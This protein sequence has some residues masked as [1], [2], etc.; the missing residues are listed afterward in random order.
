VK[1][2]PHR[3]FYLYVGFTLLITMA[4]A[5]APSQYTPR[6]WIDFPKDGSQFDQAQAISVVAHAALTDGIGYVTL[7]VDSLPLDQKSPKEAGTIFSDFTFTW[8]PPGDGDYTLVLALYDAKGTLRASATSRVK[9]GKSL[10]F[11]P[12][13]SSTPTTTPTF[14][15]VTPTLTQTLTPI[16]TPTITPTSPLPITLKLVT[17]RSTVN[18]GECAHLSWF[19]EN[20]E[21]VY[22][23]GSEVAS[24][25]SYDACPAASQTYTLRAQRG[26]ESREESMTISVNAG[27]TTAPPVPQLMVPANGLSAPCKVAQSL[28]WLPVTDPS[29]LRGYDLDVEQKVGGSWQEF[30]YYDTLKDKQYSL[31]VEC[32]YD[33]RWRVR[34]TDYQGNISAWSGWFTFVIPLG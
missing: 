33:Y 20:A 7:G 6:A 19:V 15:T 32:G 10:T 11:T 29:G 21:V 18:A 30:F 25:G 5:C 12:V 31:P 8:T 26:S 28:A 34:A 2:F 27:D 14:F 23:N 1:T 17:D 3:R 22:F 24:T 13:I 9:I 4:A 16:L